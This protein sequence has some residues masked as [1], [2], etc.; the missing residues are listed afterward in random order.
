MIFIDFIDF[1]D[2]ISFRPNLNITIKNNI[3]SPLPRL[4]LSIEKLLS[5]RSNFISLSSDYTQLIHKV[6]LWEC[7]RFCLLHQTVKFL[8]S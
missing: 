3:K 2:F 7:M 8:Q 5:H 1:F 6:D 4:P